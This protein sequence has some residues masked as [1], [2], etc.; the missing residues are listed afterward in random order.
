MA[1]AQKPTSTAVA[2]SSEPKVL[3]LTSAQAAK[4]FVDAYNGRIGEMNGDQQATFLMALGTLIGVRPELGELI[5]YQN[6]PYITI[7][8]RVR[9]AHRTGLLVGL[10]PRPATRMEKENYGVG[11]GETLWVCDCYRRGAPRAFKGW[12]HVKKA[13]DERNPVAKSNPREMAKKRSRYD[14]LRMAFPAAEE[15]TPMHQQYIEEAEAQIR[16]GNSL[17][18]QAYAALTAGDAEVPEEIETEGHEVAADSGDGEL[19]LNDAP[20]QRTG[21]PD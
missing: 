12:G 19:G 10:E 20:R 7:D 6:K 1:T 15:I 11:E 18:N 14:A 17:N 5:L 4:K 8:G 13:A 16:A 9:L 3:D 2:R 21:I